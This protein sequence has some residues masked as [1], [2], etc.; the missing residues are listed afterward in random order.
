MEEEPE[1]FRTH[2]L[3]LSILGAH[4][5]YAVTVVDVRGDGGHAVPRLS[6]ERVTGDQLGAPQWLVDVQTTEGV[7]NWYGL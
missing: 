7:V 6:V 1:R 2:L 5:R 3:Q 4:K